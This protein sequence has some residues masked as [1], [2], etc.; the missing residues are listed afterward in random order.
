MLFQ[1]R[2][3]LDQQ[4]GF[5][6]ELRYTAG[7]FVFL[8]VVFGAVEFVPDTL[9]LLFDEVDGTARFLGF[10]GEALVEVGLD[11]GVDHIAGPFG[12][13]VLK[14][15]FNDAGISSYFTHFGVAAESRDGSVEVA[16][17]QLEAVSLVAVEAGFDAEGASLDED[18]VSA[19]AEGFAGRV[20]YGVAVRAG[21]GEGQLR[22]PGRGFEVEQFAECCG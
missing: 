20:G 6:V 15:D 13:G 12:V 9:E 14:A 18:A 16:V 22:E 10:E 17:L 1:F 2:V 21:H 4:V 3:F 7:A 5:G 19:V 8:Q 11:K